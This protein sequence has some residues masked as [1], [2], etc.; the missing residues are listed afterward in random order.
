MGKRFWNFKLKYNTQKRTG[1]TLYSFSDNLC[2]CDVAGDEYK[3]GKNFL[4]LFI[5][6]LLNTQRS[7]MTESVYLLRVTVDVLNNDTI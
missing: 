7:E 4:F 2:V 1:K 5:Y 6:M 3:T